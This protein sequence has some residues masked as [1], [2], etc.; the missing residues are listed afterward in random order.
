MTIFNYFYSHPKYQKMNYRKIICIVIT[1]FVCS[2]QSDYYSAKDFKSVTKIDAHVHI[3]S[4]RGYFERQAIS[5]NFKVIT[6]GV[7][8]SDSAS[9]E[10]Q[11][12]YALKSKEKYSGNVYYAAT[13]HFD[14]L[15]WNTDSWSEKVIS[16][17]KRDIS[18]GA[19]SV[20]LWKN[21]GMTVKDKN[22]KF[23][24]IDNPAIK[25]VIDFII[26]RNLPITGHF[27]EPL[28]C[29]KPLNQMTIRGDSSYY[30]ENPQYHMFA[31]PEYP[32]YE[33]QINA[34]DH[35]L[36]IY[37]N[38]KFIG[39]HLGSLEWNVDELAK[40]LDKYPNMAVDMAARVCHLEVQCVNDREKVRNFCIKYQDRLL[41]GTDLGDYGNTKGEDPGKR[42]H[43]IWQHDWRYFTT[44]D[45]LTSVDFKGTFHGLH[46]PRQVIEKIY[47]QNSIKWYQ[48]SNK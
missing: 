13:F 34:R 41:Y 10:H 47:Y 30:A 21:I 40:R 6:I 20:K 32:S 38:L 24:M 1:L 25:P 8:E 44:D 36:E 3:S 11:H 39:C 48:L 18:G 28:N 23:I 14:T 17:L 26:S 12:I 29:W 33:D 45:E 37:P 7:D 15:G 9:V 16:H 5:D 42:T 31:H 46:L 27:G 35:F 22:G 4:D 19:I 2:C 43:E